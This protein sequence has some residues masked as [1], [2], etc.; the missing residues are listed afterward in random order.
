L[1]QDARFAL[2]LFARRPGVSLIVVFTLAIGIAATT[3]VFSLAD[4][5][6]S[7]PVP[8]RTLHL[9]IVAGRS[10]TAD[11][12]AGRMS[13]ATAALVAFG[14]AKR[15]TVVGCLSLHSRRTR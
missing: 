4:A 7:R 13:S 5:I 6:L 8:F 2:R 14:R 10:F 15:G 3:T 11:D 12:T 1:L 9:P